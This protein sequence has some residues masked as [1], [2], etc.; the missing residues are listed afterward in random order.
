MR[1]TSYEVEKT[2]C[3]FLESEGEELICNMFSKTSQKMNSVQNF[4][5]FPK[6]ASS[7][8]G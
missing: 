5:N 2:A 8:A 6:V 7:A 1:K 4:S 3:E